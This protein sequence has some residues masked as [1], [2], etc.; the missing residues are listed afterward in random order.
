LTLS[1]LRDPGPVPE[2]GVVAGP[3]AGRP[4][5]RAF[6]AEYKARVLAEYDAVEE[7]GGKGALLRREGLFSSHLVEWRRARNAGVLQALS[8]AAAG[9]ADPGAGPDRCADRAGR[10]RRAGTGQDQGGA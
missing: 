3:R 7:P 5:R 2:D 8:P 4:R 10:A 1:D 6:T 9:Q